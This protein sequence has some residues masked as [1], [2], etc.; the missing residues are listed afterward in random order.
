MVYRPAFAAAQPPDYQRFY[1]SICI[2]ELT[3]SGADYV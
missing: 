1:V 2:Y 3:F